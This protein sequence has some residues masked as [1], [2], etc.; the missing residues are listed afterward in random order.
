MRI[1]L[2]VLFSLIAVPA[3]AQSK[4]VEVHDRAAMPGFSINADVAD[5]LDVFNQAGQKIGEVEEVVGSTRETPE[6]LVVDFED[7]VVDYGPEDR[8]IPLSAFTFDGSGMVMAD[9]ITATEMP[10]WRD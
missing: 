10:R 6:A 2:P 8:I 4:M 5:D 9:G 7:Q 1:F 3:L